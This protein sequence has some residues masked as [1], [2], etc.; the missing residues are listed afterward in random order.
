MEAASALVLMTDGNMNGV[1]PVIV[2]IAAEEMRG[3]RENFGSWYCDD[4][5]LGN[6]DVT[7]D[8]YKRLWPIRVDGGGDGANTHTHTHTRVTLTLGEYCIFEV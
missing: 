8:E 7:R 1:K 2:S 3:R 5:G 4:C 6:D